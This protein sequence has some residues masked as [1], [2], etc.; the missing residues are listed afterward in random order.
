[1]ASVRSHTEAAWQPRKASCWCTTAQLGLFNHK[2]CCCCTTTYLWLLNSHEACCYCDTTYLDVCGAA[3]Q[4]RVWL[5]NIVSDTNG[6]GK[7]LFGLKLCPI[8]AVRLRVL[9]A[10]LD[11]K[12][13]PQKTIAFDHFWVPGPPRPYLLSRHYVCTYQTSPKASRGLRT[14]FP[15]NSQNPSPG[16]PLASGAWGSL[17]RL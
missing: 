5:E 15:K 16:L 14:G 17:G 2:A 3:K 12:K 7:A 11:C 6:V 10:C 13:N 1:M 9:P 4:A 8:R